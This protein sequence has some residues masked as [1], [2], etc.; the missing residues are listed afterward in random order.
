MHVCAC[1]IARH[2]PAKTPRKHKGWLRSQRT[3]SE[4]GFSFR[5][6]S[7]IR[8]LA[9]L[10]AQVGIPI[11]CKARGFLPYA[12]P[13]C[14]LA[15]L[16]GAWSP[17]T[18]EIQ[19]A[20]G[21]VVALKPSGER[22]LLRVDTARTGWGGRGRGAGG[23]EGG[24]VWWGRGGGGW[25]R[26]PWVNHGGSQVTDFRYRQAFPSYFSE[27]DTPPR[28]Q[29]IQTGACYFAVPI[30]LDSLPKLQAVC[31]YVCLFFADESQICQTVAA[32]HRGGLVGSSP[33][34]EFVLTN[35]KHDAYLDQHESRWHNFPQVGKY[36]CTK[37]PSAFA[38]L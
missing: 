22:A 21:E 18:V 3:R 31:Q 23:G 35:L 25:G 5:L 8:P 13:A 38:P 34:P 20:D 6:M 15:S 11:A 28:N 30:C 16:P 12:M 29:P 9:S 24:R 37:V 1:R 26:S 32:F 4:H 2:L 36:K 27:G 14:Q 33:G 17:H 10:G 19:G 7:D